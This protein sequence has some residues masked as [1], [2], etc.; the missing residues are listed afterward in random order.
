MQVME[1]RYR[2]L[3]EDE[4]PHIGIKDMH[5]DSRPRER[6]LSE[7]KE[8]L[9]VAELLAILI[10][11]G[12]RDK[13]AVEL[14][15]DVMRDCGDSL[16]LLDRMSIEELMSYKGIGEAK[17]ITIVAASELNNRRIQE[18]MTDKLQDFHSTDS[19]Y[20]F[21][22]MKLATLSYEESWALMLNNSA[23][24]LRAVKLSQGG[25]TGTIV[26]IR[27]L[28]KKAILAEATNVI[29]VHNHPSGSLRPSRDDDNL[30]QSAKNALLSIDIR[31][32]DHV[33][34]TDGGY[35]SYNEMGRL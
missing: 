1:E 4:S 28:L 30:T 7:G 27:I 10:G 16:A 26:D 12:S 29:L 34:I 17:A 35:Y 2:R 3:L 6:L 19:V 13:S 20:Q 25:M 31:L 23:H 8:S 22:K 9:S 5:E 18:K 32:L 11:S 24:L 33:I 14:M 15:E 21:M